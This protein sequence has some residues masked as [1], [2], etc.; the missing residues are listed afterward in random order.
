MHET[1]SSYLYWSLKFPVD[2]F[3]DILIIF[4][5]LEWYGWNVLKHKNQNKWD[6]H[7][8]YMYYRLQLQKFN[9]VF[10]KYD[11]TYSHI[12][13]YAKVFIS[14]KWISFTRFKTFYANWFRGII[15]SNNRSRINHYQ[16]HCF[17]VS[18][19]NHVLDFKACCQSVKGYKIYI[20]FQSSYS[21]TYAL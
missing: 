8:P 20:L 15:G 17:D 9:A 2:P 7:S 4:H 1:L 19:K 21:H 3:L 12:L 6:I 10:D 18:W 16:F 5:I 13:I 14:Y 11:K